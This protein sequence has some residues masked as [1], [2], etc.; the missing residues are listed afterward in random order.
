MFAATTAIVS[1]SSFVGLKFTV[2][3]PAATA[4]V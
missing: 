4:G 1:W 3:V 2:S